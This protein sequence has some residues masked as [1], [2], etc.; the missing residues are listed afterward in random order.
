MAKTYQDAITEARALLQDTDSSSY[1]YT[2]VILLAKLNRALQEIG[3]VRPDAYFDRFDDTTSAP[4]VPEVVVVDA[5]EDDN[6]DEIDADEDSQVALTDNFELE[7]QFYTPVVYFIVGSAEIL[8]DE[9]TEDGRAGMLLTQF[10][11]MLLG[12]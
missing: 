9:F 7:M 10:K 11:Q 6:P 2:D 8:D 1:R 3:R 4:L 5:D 12:L